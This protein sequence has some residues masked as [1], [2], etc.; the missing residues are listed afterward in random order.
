MIRRADYV[1][2]VLRH[3]ADPLTFMIIATSTDLAE[4]FILEL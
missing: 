3:K 2:S 4:E 1:V